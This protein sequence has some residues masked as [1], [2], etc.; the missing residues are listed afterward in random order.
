MAVVISKG[1]QVL[2]NNNK[3]QFA[4]ATLNHALPLI[5]LVPVSLMWFDRA[6]P[7]LEVKI[8]PLSVYAKWVKMGVRK[9]HPI[10]WGLFL[11]YLGPIVYRILT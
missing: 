9:M 3:K 8:W 6:V 10:F 5:L 11:I 2:N 4:I 1:K 7:H